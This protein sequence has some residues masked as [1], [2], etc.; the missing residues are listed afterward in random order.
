V[1]PIL[2][3]PEGQ[4]LHKIGYDGFNELRNK[5]MSCLGILTDSE[6]EILD[7]LLDPDFDILGSDEDEIEEICESECEVFEIDNKLTT[8][9]NGKINA[10]TKLRINDETCEEFINRFCKTYGIKLQIPKRCQSYFIFS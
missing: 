2:S 1:V 7:A 6:Q 3:Q 5:N 9:E 4:E 8:S 10:E